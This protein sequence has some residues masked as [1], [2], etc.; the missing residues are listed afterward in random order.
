MMRRR[1]G[2]ASALMVCR[3]DSLGGVGRLVPG[4]A[5]LVIGGLLGNRWR[6]GEVQGLSNVTELSQSYR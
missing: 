2:W 5:M 3:R 4:V 6:K 1:D